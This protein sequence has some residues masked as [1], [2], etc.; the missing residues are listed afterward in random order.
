MEDIYEYLI[1]IIDRKTNKE[2]YL[3]LLY[4]I[5]DE[6]HNLK[7]ECHNNINYN[8]QIDMEHIIIMNTLDIALEWN[9]EEILDFIKTNH[10]ESE[11]IQINDIIDYMGKD[12]FLLLMNNIEKEKNIKYFQYSSEPI[13]IMELNNVG[14]YYI[15]DGKHRLYNTYRKNKQNIKAYIFTSDKLEKF[16]LNEDYKKYYKWVQ[17][18]LYL[19]H[20][21]SKSEIE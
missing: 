15:I 13:I 7:F 20:S 17:K 6:F 12:E 21:L 4:E 16:L 9:V 10:L 3:K 5:K 14:T 19:G 18:L 2:Y 1:E 8:N 11:T